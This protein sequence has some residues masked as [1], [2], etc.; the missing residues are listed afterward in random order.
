MIRSSTHH[1]STRRS[2]VVWA[3]VCLFV[4]AAT[5]DAQAVRG[6]VTSRGGDDSVVVSAEVIAIA[7]GL[8]VRT[9]DRGVFRLLAGLGDSLRVRALGFRERR[10]QVSD[11]AM[12]IALDPLP[13]TL[14]RVVTTVGQREI[15][16]GESPASVTVSLTASAPVP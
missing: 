2:R 9:D 15:R 14:E 13:T 1:R 12:S 6:T 7:S 10:V 8:R 3:V 5:V 4:A 16:A 11:L